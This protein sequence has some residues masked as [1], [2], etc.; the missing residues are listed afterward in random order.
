MLRLKFV[1]IAALATGP[2]YVLAAAPDTGD[3]NTI[4]VF[5]TRTVGVKGGLPSLQDGKIFEGKK[6][7]VVDLTEQPTFVEPNLRQMFSKMPGLFVSDQ[8]IPSIYNI[9][10]RGLGNPH[11]SEFI[12]FFQN[13]VPL[14]ADL[15]GY[16]T[17][18]YMP[19]AQR[20]ERI[21]FVRGGGGLLYGPQI[22]PALNFVTRRADANAEA[23]FSTDQSAGSNGLYSTYNEARWSSGDFG[24]MASF[25]HRSAD[26]PR[27]NEDYEVNAGYFGMSYQGFDQIRL[28][29][30]IDLYQSDSGEA[31]RLT[32]REF[33]EDRNLTKSPHNRVDIKQ[34]IATF[35]YEQQLSEAATLDAKVWYKGM[36]RLSRRS[37]MFTD[38]VNEPR[39]TAID[40]QQFDSLGFDLRYAQTWGGE[41]V[42]TLGT[43][44]YQGDSPRTRHVSNDI[45]SSHQN[46]ADLAFAQDRVINYSAVFIENLFRFGNLSVSPSIRH[47][48]I[49][50]DLQ[51]RVTSASLR[52]GAIDLDRTSNETLF[53]LGLLYQLSSNSEFYANISESYRPQRFDD[54][55]N[56][57]SE[58][59]GSNGPG[60]SSAVNYEVGY[61]SQATAKLLFDISLFRIDFED[62]I[63]Q[64]QTNIADVE[65]INSGDSRHQGIEF[66]AEYDVL[67][68][69]GRSLALFAN[70]SLLDTEIINSVNASLVGNEASFAPGHVVRTGFIYNDDRW[71][72]SL[73]ATLVG[74][75]YWQDSNLPRGS[76]AN[77]IDAKIPA[78]EV[79]DVS[80]EYQPTDR[81]SLFGGINNLLNED[82][83][84][85]VRNDGIEPSLERTVY[86]GLRLTLE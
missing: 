6:T 69:G 12:G 59:A 1:V 8:Q 78:Y 65:R 44:G 52:R 45:R 86:L 13:N 77:T 51:D 64:I 53:G 73:T 33:A 15:F 27:I 22:G 29:F 41:H 39:T 34:L 2:S 23:S 37:A 79:V 46:P 54:L 20:V 57:A 3:L 83:F 47:E 84:S 30:D 11:E 55:I 61:R 50:Y 70:G 25:D 40:E 9:N 7:T 32:S 42:L 68:E 56:P 58:L 24:F 36:D 31:G 21:E 10:Y 17:I 75:Q 18:Y 16:P 28:G 4:E 48:R 74:D 60:V 49:N 14:A 81:W 35:T 62:K 26:G 66:S 80:A 82:Y 71:N 43:T 76:A 5:G 63:E 85:R 67:R 19:A 38:P 72:A